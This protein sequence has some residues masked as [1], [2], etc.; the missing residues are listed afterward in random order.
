MWNDYRSHRLPE[1]DLTNLAVYEEIGAS[2]D[3]ETIENCDFDSYERIYIDALAQRDA[4]SAIPSDHR[5]WT[6]AQGPA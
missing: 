5:L 2:L 3:H 1:P 6:K 4:V